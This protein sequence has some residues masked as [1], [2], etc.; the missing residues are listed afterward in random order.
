[1]KKGIEPKKENNTQTQDHINK[2]ENICLVLFAVYV[3]VFFA[4]VFTGNELMKGLGIGIGTT[5]AIIATIINTEEDGED[6]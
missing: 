6:E 1:M 5:V 2:I 3:V 4:G